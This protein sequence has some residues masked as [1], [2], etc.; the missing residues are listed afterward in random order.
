M[1]YFSFTCVIQMDNA[2]IKALKNWNGDYGYYK[3]LIAVI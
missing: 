1:L 3:V 2:K